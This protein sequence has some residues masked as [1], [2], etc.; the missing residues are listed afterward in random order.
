MTLP[1]M[2]KDIE[3]TIKKKMVQVS[4]EFTLEEIGRLLYNKYNTTPVGPEGTHI[5][6]QH[7]VLPTFKNNDPDE[8]VCGVKL[9]WEEE[10]VQGVDTPGLPAPLKPKPAPLK[11]KPAP[12]PF[13]EDDV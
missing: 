2:R 5:P 9:V 11:P 13:S 6:M 7:R 1:R 8:D 12:R 3:V 4:V 10:P